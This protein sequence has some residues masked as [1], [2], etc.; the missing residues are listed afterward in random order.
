M[1][2]LKKILW[3][4]LLSGLYPCVDCKLAFAQ[5]EANIWYFGYGAG[6]DFN[7]GTPV[8][9]TNSAMNSSE[10]SA[11]ISDPSGQLLFYTDG[12]TVWDRTHVVMFSGSS[13]MGHTSTT[14]SSLIVPEPG[15][16]T[17]YY[18]F[19]NA[20]QG[21]SVP[22]NNSW[23]N[24][25]LSYS[26]VDMSLNGGLGDVTVKN[27]SLVVPTSEKLTGIKHCNGIDY[28]VIVHEFNTNAFY[29]YLITSAGISAPVISNAGIVHAGLSFQ[30]QIKASPNG[31]RLASAIVFDP[32]NRVELFDF[33]NT[34]GVISNAV[35]VSTGDYAYGVEFSPDNSKLYISSNH[36]GVI[37]YSLGCGTISGRTVVSPYVGSPNPSTKALQLGPNGRI[38][39]ARFANY[40]FLEEIRNPNAAGLACNYVV[41]GV[42]L[43]T[44]SCD[45]GLPN[46]VQSYFNHA[47]PG[48]PA[49]NFLG[50]DT[51]LCTPPYLLNAGPVCNETYLWSTG[52]TTQTISINTSGTYWVKIG[53]CQTSTDTIR[54]TFGLSF[55]LSQTSANCGN[56]SGAATVSVSGGAAPFTYNW[57]NGQSTQT[58]TGLAVGNY[59]ATITDA[60]GCS[61]TQSITITSS[62][63]TLSPATTSASCTLNDGTATVT[64]GGGISPFTYN[65][66]NGQTTQTATALTAGN[67]SATVT[68]ANGCTSVQI[69]SVT[70]NNNNF[71]L[72]ISSTQAGCTVNNGTATVNTSGGSN[73]FTYS[74]NNSQVT[75]MATG[76]AAG[77]YT[78]MVTDANGCTQTETVTITASNT[79]SVTVSYTQAGCTISN[80][81]ATAN[82][83]GGTNPLTYN[84]D[85]GQ[86]MQTATALAASTYT[87][88]VTD[89]NGCSQSQSVIVT[90]SNTL[91]VSVVST[92]AGCTVNNGTATANASGGSAPLTYNWNNG[93]TTQAATSLTAGIYTVN[94]TD[95]NGCTQ[96]QTVSVTQTP[97]PSVSASASPNVIFAGTST[98]L[99]VTGGTTYVWS[100]STGLSCITCASPVASPN[101]TTGYCVTATDGNGCTDNACVTVLVE[102]DCANSG[103]LFIPN[104]F[105]P[106]GDGENDFIQA[107]YGNLQCIE[108]FKLV[109]YNRWG[110]KVFQSTDPLFTWDGNYK[111]STEGSAAFAYYIEAILIN[112]E[113]IIKKGNV[114]LFR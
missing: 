19:A 15:S 97:G 88:I 21:G 77:T 105:S 25:G 92:Q 107:Y 84:W 32:Q 106:N 50:K 91:S 75:Q 13:L 47:G 101:N 111:N 33:N 7:S 113:E 112:G 1:K 110:Q 37:Q 31:K 51:V 57:S 8:A 108:T 46:F 67:Y 90:A 18:V 83:S 73:P 69:V 10:G 54:V 86:T 6:L 94:V 62:T 5:G 28:W 43:G 22:A 93:Q 11:V 99:S 23:S 114:S 44:K 41:G 53:Q 14:Q 16:S 66:S 96:I 34:T 100:P 12:V 40:F 48:T 59:T 56:N 61:N 60:S 55:S 27:Q 95:A 39:A 65:W 38:Y 82:T 49:G 45:Y 64:P 42:S 109:I 85:N 102:I 35:L 72:S 98:T 30:G 20:A 2:L 17:L 80:G 103:E 68:D 71:S 81:T 87:V 52:A 58:A 63:F 3:S 26:I 24:L 36:L 79:L 78:T 89:A 74:W 29:S 76:L 9:L 70:S 104:A 4:T